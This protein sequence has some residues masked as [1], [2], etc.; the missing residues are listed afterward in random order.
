[1][2]EIY[3]LQ[4]LLLLT[5]SII[6]LPDRAVVSECETPAPLSIRKKALFLIL[7]AAVVVVVAAPP[8]IMTG[9]D[10]NKIAHYV[11]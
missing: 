7:L 1:M 6:F 2:S 8:V 11:K 5:R 9:M 3:H 10:H 4:L